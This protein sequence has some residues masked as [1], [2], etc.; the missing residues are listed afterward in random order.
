M[1]LHL[2]SQAELN[3]FYPPTPANKKTVERL[4][5]SETLMCLDEKDDKG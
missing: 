1:S 3:E 5:R 2:C 4:K